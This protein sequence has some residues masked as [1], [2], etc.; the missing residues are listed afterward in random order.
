MSDINDQEYGHLMD[1]VTQD[2]VPVTLD[3][4]RVGDIVSYHGHTAIFVGW[5]EWNGTYPFHAVYHGGMWNWREA[6]GMLRFLRKD[7]VA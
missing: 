4:L 1:G 6:P 3:E 2:R 7:E 5:Q